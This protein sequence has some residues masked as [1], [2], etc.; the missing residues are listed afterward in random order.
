MQSSSKVSLTHNSP[1][2]LSKADIAPDMA[3]MR[4]RLESE[5]RNLPEEL[6]QLQD[7]LNQLA[8]FELGRFLIKNKSLSGYWTWYIIQGFK[9]YNISSPLE[10]FILEKAPTVIATQQRFAIFQTLLKSYIQSGDKVCSIPCG[11]MADLLTLDLTD[12]I[13]NIHFVGIDLD[14]SVFDEARRLVKKLQAGASYEF[15]QKDAWD[16]STE[17]EFNIITT[18]G[19]NIYEPDD[20]R[21]VELY[22]SLY[23]ALKANGRLICSALTLPPTMK[24]S[25]WD[26]EKINKNDLSFAVTLFKSILGAT[27]SNFRSSAKTCEQLASAGFKNIEIHWDSQKMFPTFSAQ[28]MV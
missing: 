23:H 19:L 20:S 12:Q 15:I 14:A 11:M 17:N 27:W 1:D 4:D 26:M 2:K 7:I 28:K 8:E 10:K 21:V 24:E 18:N 25:E 13:E 6:A 9:N 22:R 3:S 16:L 5:Y